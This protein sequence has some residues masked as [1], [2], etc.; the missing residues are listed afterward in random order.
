MRHFI[1]YD[2]S[3]A[4]ESVKCPVL[5]LNGEKD[6]QVSSKEN[7]EAIKNSLTK[8]GNKKVTIK[9]L[10]GLNYLFQESKTGLPTEYATIGQTFSPTALIEISNWINE[11]TR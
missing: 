10:P 6:L 2:P 5:A 3:L 9:E 1:Q 8:G 4:L 11:Q 7:L